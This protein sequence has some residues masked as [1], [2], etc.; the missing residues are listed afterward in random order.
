[1]K[2]IRCIRRGVANESAVAFWVKASELSGQSLRFELLFRAI[3]IKPRKRWL[4]SGKTCVLLCE[5][6]FFWF[7]QRLHPLG[8]ESGTFCWWSNDWRN[9]NYDIRDSWWNR[10]KQN[11]RSNGWCARGATPGTCGRRQNESSVKPVG[12]GGASL[13]PTATEIQ[14]MT[15]VQE[16]RTGKPKEKPVVK[17]YV[18]RIWMQGR[19][20]WRRRRVVEHLSKPL[21]SDPRSITNWQMTGHLRME[22]RQKKKYRS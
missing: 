6:Q 20:S 1:M 2:R 21:V 9:D 3:W 4:C 7:C 15:S 14:T 5:L 22:G 17:M 10:A 11:R 19:Q 18:Q 8:K 12:T 13:I 16:A